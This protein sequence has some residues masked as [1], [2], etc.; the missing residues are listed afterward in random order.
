[1]MATPDETITTLVSWVTG[2]ACAPIANLA[3]FSDN[4]IITTT[5]APWTKIG[6]TV[7][8]TLLGQDRA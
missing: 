4:F 5:A 1:M 6:L 2:N 7:V 8:G 3:G